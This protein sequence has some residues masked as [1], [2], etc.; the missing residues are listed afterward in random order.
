M[1]R[2]HKPEN[3]EVC[4]DHCMPRELADKFFAP[5]IRDLPLNWLNEWFSAA[6][7]IEGVSK[8]LWTYLTPRILEV[9]A[10]GELPDALGLEVTMQRYPIGQESQWSSKQWRVIDKFQRSYLKRLISS[11][12]NLVTE[13]LDDVLCMF[14]AGGWSLED[15]LS[16]VTA[17]PTSQLAERLWQEWC[18]G[19][20]E[21]G[22]I[23]ITA[24][25]K[26][27]DE[28]R[29][30]D[31]YTSGTLHKVFLDIALNDAHPTEIVNRA[32]DLV[33]VI[34]RTSSANST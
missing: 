16:Q 13:N 21:F 22:T 15:L 29:M 25:W 2:T 6:A 19:F 14:R 10:A 3:V 26:A 18:E 7:A 12:F 8:H 1:F 32:L 33:S 24:F 17:A 23:W 20:S 5:E 11:D 31:F 27:E 30:R 4:I 28:T 34:E 9:L